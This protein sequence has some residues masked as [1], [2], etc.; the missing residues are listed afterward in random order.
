MAIIPIS[1]R[2]I[3]ISDTVNLQE[4]KSSTVNKET[5][6]Y[7]LQDFIDSVGGGGLEGT[8]YVYVAA[9]GTDL[10]NAVQLQDA[11]DTAQ[12]M[13]PSAANR[14][15]VI[16]GP[17][18]YNFSTDFVMDV[19]YI[20]LVSLDGNRSVIFNG[21]GTI[22]ITANDVFVK[23][24]DVLLKAFTVATLLDLLKVENCAGGDFSFGGAVIAAGTFTNCIGGTA[25]FG[26]SFPGGATGVFTD[27]V[28]GDASFASGSNRLA[29]GTFTNCVGGFQS[30]GGAGGIAS[31]TFTNCTAGSQSFGESGTA[32]GTF[33]N[34]KSSTFS[35][36]YNG[37]ASGTFTDCVGLDNCFGTNGTASGTFTN[38]Q[39]GEYAFGTYG[40]ASGT[41][42][43]C[44]AGFYCFGGFGTASGTFTNCQAEGD[45]FGLFGVLSGRLY[46]CRLTSDFA[47][48]QLVDPGGITRLC[49]DGNNAEDNQGI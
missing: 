6:P 32:S 45:S 38:C 18:N 39:G 42:T 25:S 2:F 20:D 40:T 31:G 26:G 9:D 48:F 4:R 11:Y 49:I 41:F 30:F 10:E 34:C 5:E 14:V 3:G 8:S 1:T 22:S 33:T 15:K 37:T 29:S 12:T 47:T 46:Y 19:Q 43:N 28:G 36:G 17:G 23:G 27:C 13:S 16:C 44:T 21:L 35:F 24:V 7:S